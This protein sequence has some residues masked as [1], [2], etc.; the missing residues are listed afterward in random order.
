[1]MRGFDYPATPLLA[2]KTP[3]PLF[4]SIALFIYRRKKTTF[5]I[6][7]NLLTELARI[8]AYKVSDRRDHQDSWGLHIVIY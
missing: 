8:H 5:G 4:I 2:E 3:R 1:M 6:T 7:I